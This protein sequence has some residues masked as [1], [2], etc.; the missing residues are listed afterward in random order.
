M[1]DSVLIHQSSL[2]MCSAMQHQQLPNQ[3]RL[4]VE[5]HIVFVDAWLGSS[6]V[7]SLLVRQQH[8]SK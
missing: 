1:E 6:T 8:K 2:Q 3:W 4:P 5:Q 7:L